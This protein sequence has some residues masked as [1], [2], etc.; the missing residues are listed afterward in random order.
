MEIN[1]LDNHRL[2]L[3]MI[4]GELHYFLKYFRALLSVGELRYKAKFF[5]AKKLAFFNMKINQ[6]DNHSSILDMIPNHPQ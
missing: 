3:D 6:L 4:G 2:I 1:Q 5:W